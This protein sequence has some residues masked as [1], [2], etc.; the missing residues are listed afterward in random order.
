[1]ATIEQ[2]INTAKRAAGYVGRLITDGILAH[3][4]GN[5]YTPQVSAKYKP[6]SSCF[7]HCAA[8]FLQEFGVD[9]NPDTVTTEIN[10]QYW[11]AVTMSLY[12]P[13]VA[14]RYKGNRQTLWE[15]QLQYI[16]EKLKKAHCKKRAIFGTDLTRD[17]AQALL[18]KGPVIIGTSPKYQ[19]RT[20]GHVMLLVGVTTDGHYIIDDPFGDFST[21]YKSHA[22]GNDIRVPAKD[23]HKIFS[24]LY[25]AIK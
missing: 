10:S 4:R 16:T 14:K 8:W 12:G 25:I 11:D 13:E 23:A 9:I 5:K 20:L 7:S 2:L 24:G 18:L 6:Y 1:M 15:L 21:G 19:G 3:W 22:D 17:K